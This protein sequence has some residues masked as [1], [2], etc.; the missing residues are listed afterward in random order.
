M[1]GNR[2]GHTS[3]HWEGA[4][5]GPKRSRADANGSGKALA[6]TS[7]THQAR[8]QTADLKAMKAP[9]R[10][11]STALAAVIV[12]LVIA[13][14]APV[15]TAEA[16]P[17]SG[18]RTSSSSATQLL[19]LAA[20]AMLREAGVAFSSSLSAVDGSQTFTAI[21]KGKYSRTASTQYYEED[22]AGSLEVGET[23]TIGSA[24]YCMGN[25]LFL[26]EQCN[27]SV[28]SARAAKDRWVRLNPGTPQYNADAPSGISG[29]VRYGI[30]PSD[31]DK[32]AHSGTGKVAGTPVIWL[33]GPGTMGGVLGSD[34]WTE[35][36]AV[37]SKGAPLV[38]RIVG[39]SPGQK[40]VVVDGQKL[41]YHEVMTIS[42]WGRSV[43]ISPPAKTVPYAALS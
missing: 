23:R 24:A 42:A 38:L 32:Y 29:F 33:T 41:V 17:P 3:R 31:P 36:I 14:P 6:E 39:S 4:G 19:A 34:P 12:C 27:F 11:Q 1:L 2:H 7:K 15:L 26:Q 8:L 22:A 35:T 16:S 5:S 10:L 18:S 40:P 30:L 21:S 37:A 20:Q 28:S 9:R 43:D 25:M 13:S